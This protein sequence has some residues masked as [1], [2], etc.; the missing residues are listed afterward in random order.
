MCNALM[1]VNTPVASNQLI[2]CV[3]TTDGLLHFIPLESH[4]TQP[5]AMRNARSQAC[6]LTRE[7]ADFNEE[8]DVTLYGS[9][10]LTGPV[11]IK[12]ASDIPEFVHNGYKKPLPRRLRTFADDERML[13]K[14]DLSDFPNRSEGLLS[15]GVFD[16]ETDI[17][18]R[19]SNTAATL[20]LAGPQPGVTPG[21]LSE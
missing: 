7:C 18:R 16:P 6:E 13:H 11:T 12:L 15:Q 19:L 2:A 17:L 21:I 10:A 5:I 20:T 1:L 4:G 8:G 3:G 9:H 14:I